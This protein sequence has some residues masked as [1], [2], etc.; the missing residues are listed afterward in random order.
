VRITKHLLFYATSVCYPI[1]ASRFS[2]P[3]AS[4][5][6]SQT[7]E[8]QNRGAKAKKIPFRVSFSYISASVCWRQPQHFA[9]SFSF[10][11]DARSYVSVVRLFGKNSPP[12]LSG[13]LQALQVVH[14]SIWVW[15]FILTPE[16]KCV[17]CET[18]AS[19]LSTARLIVEGFLLSHGL[20]LL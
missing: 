14:Q 12:A 13:G 5:P 6:L 9:C 11:K 3:Q 8:G 19:L 15:V 4:G 17:C 1:P 18:K 20:F 7:E 16:K 2:P 10:L